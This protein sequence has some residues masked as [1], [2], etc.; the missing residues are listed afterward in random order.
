MFWSLN[1][2]KAGIW[3]KCPGS[4]QLEMSAVKEEPGQP[5][6]EGDAAHEV[7]MKIL[8]GEANGV[9]DFINT[10]A[11]NGVFIDAVM[12]DHVQTYVDHVRDAS[13]QG[14][15]E[16]PLQLTPNIK[17]VV[18]H[19]EI[20]PGV[21]KCTELKYGWS[22]VEVRKN[23]QLIVNALMSAS[24]TASPINEYTLCIFQPRAPHRDGPIREWTITSDE[25][26]D[27]RTQVLEQEDVAMEPEAPLITGDHCHH[28]E[29]KGSCPALQR[30][31]LRAVETEGKAIPEELSPHQLAQELRIMEA[32]QQRIKDRYT[33]LKTVAET[34]LRGGQPVPGFGIEPS[35]GNRRWKKGVTAATIQMMS[36]VDIAKEDMMTPQQAHRAG[37]SEKTINSYTTRSVSSYKLTHVDVAEKAKELFGND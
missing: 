14:Y 18:D 7:A 17:G 8:R 1:P 31:A 27:Y 15:I 13:G 35:Y 23:W 4:A 10:N 21:L 22:P 9:E 19:F 33:G 3:M 12:A 29:A 11:T 37:V 26:E 24:Y 5:R 2:H 34:M 30:T 36:G 16:V 6:L 28:C 25:M 32:A 20:G